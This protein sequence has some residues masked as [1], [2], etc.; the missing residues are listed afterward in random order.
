VL[1]DVKQ[2]PEQGDHDW[3]VIDDEDSLRHVRF[4]AIRSSASLESVR[5]GGPSLAGFSIAS[6]DCTQ[7]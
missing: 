4:T 6:A 5:K 3:L 7:S 1:D 2:I